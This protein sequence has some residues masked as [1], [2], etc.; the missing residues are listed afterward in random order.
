MNQRIKVIYIFL[1]WIAIGLVHSFQSY[2]YNL[3]LKSDCSIFT[4][5]AYYL[6]EYTLWSFYTLFIFRIT[7]TYTFDSRNWYKSLAVHLIL[8]IFITFFHEFTIYSIRWFFYTIS[9]NYDFKETYTDYLKINVLSSFFLP[10]ILYY[11]TA[12]VGYTLNYYKKY[13]FHEMERM[14]IERLLV[15]SQL[16]GLK[17]N[18]HPH[19]LFNT[20]NTVSMLI[21]QNKS[22]KSI[23]LIA[24][25]GELLRY[26]LENREN[27]WST[28]GQEIEIIKQYLDIEK[29]RFQKRLTYI[30]NIP[31]KHYS[32]KI[33]DLLLQPLIENSIKHGLKDTT[34]NGKISIS[35]SVKDKLMCLSIRDN[36]SGFNTEQMKEG[37]GLRSTRE[38]LKKLYNGDAYIDIRSAPSK[39]S[40]VNISIPLDSI[41]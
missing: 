9:P 2:L 7:E 18:L 32:Q 23:E 33:P 15:S 20:L 38:R 10:L 26:M 1:F 21:R 41:D 35:S 28:L 3:G 25:L 8:S 40:I 14:N 5:L 11:G 12:V 29:I 31:E 37:F 22:D 30:V 34:E 16:E 4:Y 39:G 19:F 24:K 27:N 6:P 17:N 36:G 13:R